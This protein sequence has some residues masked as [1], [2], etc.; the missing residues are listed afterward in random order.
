MCAPVAAM[1]TRETTMMRETTAWY[2][3]PAVVPE[4]DRLAL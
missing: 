1:G 2:Q 3:S 4:A